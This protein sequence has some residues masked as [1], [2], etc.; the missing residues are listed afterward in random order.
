MSFE[1]TTPFLVGGEETVQY[2]I[3]SVQI[4]RVM[5]L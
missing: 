5:N 1:P 2:D 4:T 3:M